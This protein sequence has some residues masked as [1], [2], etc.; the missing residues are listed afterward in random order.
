MLKEFR[1]KKKK[2]CQLTLPHEIKGIRGV[3]QDLQ[4]TGMPVHLTRQ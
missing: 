1:Q 3:F 4:G 2:K